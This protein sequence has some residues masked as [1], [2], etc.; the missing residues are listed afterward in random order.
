M[1]IQ[2][3]KYETVYL[4]VLFYSVVALFVFIAVFMFTDHGQDEKFN[5]K[6]NKNG[7][8]SGGYANDAGRH[9]Q[10]PAVLNNNNWKQMPS[11]HIKIAK[12]PTAKIP[13]KKTDVIL[14]DPVNVQYGIP[15]PI[16]KDNMIDMLLK[17]ADQELPGA[18]T[19]DQVK[20]LKESGNLIY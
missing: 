7:D 20:Q 16:Y 18:L 3:V 9:N 13:Y 6:H 8:K 1:K 15:M 10:D 4:N 5:S 19:K 14:T 11:S 2:N 17:D 12:T